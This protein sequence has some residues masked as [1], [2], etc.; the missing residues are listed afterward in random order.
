MSICAK[1]P[2]YVSE[3]MFDPSRWWPPAWPG[4]DGTGDERDPA[5]TSTTA[6]KL[7][8]CPLRATMTVEEAAAY[9]GIGRSAAYEAARS[10]DLPVIRLGRRLLVPRAALERMLADCRPRSEVGGKG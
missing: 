4:S 2:A 5:P 8:E 3:I 9:L 7:G 1:S 6:S 10:G